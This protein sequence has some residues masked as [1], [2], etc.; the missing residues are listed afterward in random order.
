MQRRASRR[1][2]RRRP[3]AADRTRS[4]SVATPRRRRSFDTSAADNSISPSSHD[5]SITATASTPSKVRKVSRACDF[6]K[7]RKAKCSGNQ[8]CSKC[9][10]K[11]RTCLYTAKYTRGRPPTPPASAVASSRQAPT[12][13]DRGY[14]SWTDN[15]VQAQIRETSDGAL[16]Q[17][18]APSRASPELGMAEI[19]GQVFDPT[20][21]MTFLHRAWKRLS[22]ETARKIPDAVGTSAEDQPLSMAG[23]RPLP[24]LHEQRAIRL[25]SPDESRRL[26]DLYFDV[27]IATYRILHRPAVEKWLTILECS[28]DQ[29]RPVWHE[30]GRARAS[31]VLTVLAIATEHDAKSNE[32]ASTDASSTSPTLSDE[33]FCTSLRLAETEQGYPTLESAQARILQVLYL[34]TTSRFNKSWYVFGNALQIISTIGLH[35][36]ANSKRRGKSTT[37]YVQRQGRLR[38]FW[39]AYI[40]DNYLGV[41]F[42]RPR[43]FHD[44]D[45]DQEFPDRANDDDMTAL[46][47]SDTPHTPMSC[48]VDALIFHAKIAQILGS[49]SRE[50]YTIKEM[51]EPDRAS[52]ARR[53]IQRIHEWHASLPIH[54]GSVPP[55]ILIH[56]YRRQ[57]TVIKLAH[58]HA[59][60]HAG[61]LFLLSNSSDALAEEEAVINAARTA[62]EVVDS[63]AP[64]GS[65][66]HAFWW[67]H[68]VTFCALVIVY[69][70]EIQQRRQGRAT[71]DDGRARLLQLAERCQGH[72][73]RATATN[74]PSRRYAVILE[75]FKPAAAAS[76]PTSRH[77]S[78]ENTQPPH[79]APAQPGG[80]NAPQ[81]PGVQ[82]YGPA[83]GSEPGLP[84]DPH[85]L[86]EWQTTDW[87]ELDSSAFWPQIDVGEAIVWPGIG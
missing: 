3:A 32:R 7:I 48:H 21:G 75:E 63:M 47:P 33:F 24:E 86:D 15:H 13:Q 62:L 50:V 26:L 45:I 30:V 71:G 28:N 79:G 69:V 55:S 34:L 38:T 40:L 37:D 29:G 68:Y 57:A 70:W 11:R 10:A 78:E 1:D 73:A 76:Y 31:I 80:P 64:E 58:A 72:L 9:I 84:L 22:D 83:F 20:S 81:A 4:S 77:D 2:T 61:R 46:G 87:L 74:S 60:M 8:P 56:S 14:L 82:E 54:L 65:I 59:I 43:H 42:G 18:G 85:L 66:F 36:E 17:S 27:C 53:H 67:T 16:H 19:Q 39:T 41:V 6:C 52:A 23:D 51:P 12:R 25:P 44:E 35:R 49:I 5:L